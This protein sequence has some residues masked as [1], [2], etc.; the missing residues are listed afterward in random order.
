MLTWHFQI[1]NS[2]DD[3]ASVDKRTGLQ[4]LV[5]LSVANDVSVWSKVCI[6][7][8]IPVTICPHSSIIFD[9]DF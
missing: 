9:L 4:Q 2:S 7:V 8:S 6:I 3:N 1:G 5:E